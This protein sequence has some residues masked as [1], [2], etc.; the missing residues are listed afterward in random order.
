MA[1]QGAGMLDLG[2][3]LSAEAAVLPTT[4]SFD[5]AGAKNWQATRKL[6]V[7]NLSSRTLRL[8]IAAD[9]QQS[10]AGRGLVFAAAPTRLSIAPGRWAS[11]YV[12]GRIAFQ[13][14]PSAPIEGLL[15]APPKVAPPCACRG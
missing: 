15:Q 3:A 7:R 4:L 11:V 10:A 1:A 14:T 8:R 2:A 12:T 13:G 6:I 9:D 5:H